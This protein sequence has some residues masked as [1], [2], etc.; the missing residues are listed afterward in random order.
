MRTG[1]RGQGLVPGGFPVPGQQ[2]THPGV[3]QL[4]DAGE[5]IGDRDQLPDGGVSDPLRTPTIVLCPQYC[6]AIGGSATATIRQVVP[7]CAHSGPGRAP[8][9]RRAASRSQDQVRPPERQRCALSGASMPC[10]RT[11]VPRVSS[12]S[13]AMSRAGPESVRSAVA[14]SSVLRT[15]PTLSTSQCARRCAARPSVLSIPPHRAHSAP[16][17]APHHRAFEPLPT[18][19]CAAGRPTTA[20]FDAR[21]PGTP[22]PGGRGPPG[23]GHLSQ[24]PPV[25]GTADKSRAC[26]LRAA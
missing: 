19:R 18:R 24:R 26:S 15:T 21:R 10:S 5:D 13:P 1:R 23:A 14:P 3:R 2:L 11:R 16:T 4:G 6:V 12:V 7:P 20:Q 8:R 9:T 22:L 25:S 17:R